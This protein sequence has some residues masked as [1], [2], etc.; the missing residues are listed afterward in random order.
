MNTDIQ[1]LRSAFGRV[2]EQPDN[3]AE[4]VNKWREIVT[5]YIVS[6]DLHKVSM[7][8]LQKH[9][10][11]PKGLMTAVCRSLYENPTIQLRHYKFTVS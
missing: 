9:F 3:N 2:S 6:N 10:S 7:S 4:D 11:T 8:Q 1:T 5:A